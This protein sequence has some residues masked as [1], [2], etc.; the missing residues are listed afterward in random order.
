VK[1]ERAAYRA[2]NRDK[3]KE[4]QA[5]SRAR[6]PEETRAKKNAWSKT[7]A[8]ANPAKRSVFRRN[9]RARE[10]TAEGSHTIEDVRRIYAAQK[11][12]CACCKTKVGNTYHVDH[13]Q[14]LSKGG[15]NWPSNLQI[16]CP[17]CNLSKSDRN[18]VE[19]MQARGLLI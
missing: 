17:T 12:K 1:E 15:S 7:W 18:P 11:G 8:K 2:Q 3:L 19:F 6:N 16:L 9:R 13:I 10:L 4:R 5:A 14:P